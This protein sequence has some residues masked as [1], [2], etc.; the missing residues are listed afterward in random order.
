[1]YEERNIKVDE[2]KLL[3]R[4]NILIYGKLNSFI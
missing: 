4:F 3:F 2:I 1:M